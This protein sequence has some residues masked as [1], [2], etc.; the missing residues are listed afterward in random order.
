[1]PFSKL[2][3]CKIGDRKIMLGAG[4]IAGPFPFNEFN[5]LCIL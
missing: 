1:M 5:F 4:G 2:T 3:H